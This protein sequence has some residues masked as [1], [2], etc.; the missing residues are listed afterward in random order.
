MRSFKLED[1]Y[2]SLHI[3][4]VRFLF[5]RCVCA[6][7]LLWFHLLSSGSPLSTWSLVEPWT[8]LLV[9][10]PIQTS[11]R[12][13]L[14][15]H[16]R[17]VRAAGPRTPEAGR[18]PTVAGSAGL[19]QPDRRSGLLPSRRPSS[20][21][22]SSQRRLGALGWGW[23]GGGKISRCVQEGEEREEEKEEEE[24]S[25]VQT[26]V[27]LLETEHGNDVQ[28]DLRIFFFYKHVTELSILEMLTTFSRSERPLK[29]PFTGCSLFGPGS[30]MRSLNL[31]LETESYI[32]SC[33]TAIF[34]HSLLSGLSVRILMIHVHPLQ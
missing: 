2:I 18:S 17:P 29:C 1:Y 3:F 15:H 8:H 14:Q 22:Q 21:S 10:L 30:P 16:S 25:P 19:L 24:M 4:I 6:M 33:F 28:Q 7:A 23:G 34:G 32:S 12:L 20:Q 11:K 27:L 26:E 9:S 13:A 5:F 31:S